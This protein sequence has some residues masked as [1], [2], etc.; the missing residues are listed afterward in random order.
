MIPEANKHVPMMISPVLM[1]LV[2][3]KYLKSGIEIATPMKAAI[4][5]N[6]VPTLALITVASS[7]LPMKKMS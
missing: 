5:T 4:P 1:K 3:L 6:K 2:L 7:V